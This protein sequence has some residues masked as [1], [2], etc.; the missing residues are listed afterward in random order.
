MTF[1][2]ASLDELLDFCLEID[3]YYIDL[4]GNTQEKYTGKTEDAI[5]LMMSILSTLR[6]D[7]VPVD[8]VMMFHDHGCF[9]LYTMREADDKR[10]FMR[11]TADGPWWAYTVYGVEGSFGSD[12]L[13][14]RSS[15]LVAPGQTR[16]GM[17]FPFHRFRRALLAV[18]PD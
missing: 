8:L 6:Q 3:E 14:S 12:Q 4:E 7:S 11:I 2:G 10:G 15:A 9:E 16:P 18:D 13:D 17:P 5:E 1:E